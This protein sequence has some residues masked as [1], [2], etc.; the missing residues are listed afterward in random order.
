MKKSNGW[1]DNSYSLGMSFKISYL[2][3]RIFQLT[4]LKYISRNL[5][6]DSNYD[7]VVFLIVVFDAFSFVVGTPHIF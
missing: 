5:V 1:I 6:H 3:I 4:N 2:A 7:L